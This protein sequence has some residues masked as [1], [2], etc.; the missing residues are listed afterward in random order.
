[1]WVGLGLTSLTRIIIWVGFGLHISTRQPTN[2]QP[3]N[4]PTCQPDTFDPKTFEDPL[5]HY[6][7]LVI[8]KTIR[9][10]M[11]NSVR[12]TATDLF[13]LYSIFESIPCNIAHSLA[14]YFNQYT[15][16]RL[17]RN[18]MGGS[19]ITRLAKSLEFLSDQVIQGLSPPKA[20]GYV[21]FDEI[22]LMPVIST[23]LLQSATPTV[24]ESST[25]QD[26]HQLVMMFPPSSFYRHDLQPQPLPPVL[27]HIPTN[28]PQTPHAQPQ[29]SSIYQTLSPLLQGSEI[30]APPFFNEDMSLQDLIEFYQP[31]LPLIQQ[32][33]PQQSTH[34]EQQ[35]PLSDE[36]GPS[37]IPQSNQPSDLAQ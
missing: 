11:T 5:Y 15:P 7:H 21:G 3:I 24:V 23:Q 1:M 34:P 14:S 30:M 33:P 27:E 12:V 2:P 32:S 35:P 37:T 13:L 26:L 29:T 6:M 20:P 36:A 16:Q 19:Y 9:G 4:S 18:L 28:P 17:P 25:P 10:R 22:K 8:A 31:I